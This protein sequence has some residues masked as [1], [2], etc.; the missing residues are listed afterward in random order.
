MQH[1]HIDS[2]FFI[3]TLKTAPKSQCRI[4][5]AVC[6]CAAAVA[7]VTLLCCGAGCGDDDGA[8]P[9]DGG[10]DAAR[11]DGANPDAPATDAQP[12]SDAT[13]EPDSTVDPDAG[14]P[15]PVDLGGAVQK[16]PF[17]LGSSIQVSTMDASGNPTGQ[18]FNTDTENDLGEFSVVVPH[19]GLVEIEGTGFY[20][21]EVTGQLSD[22]SLTLRAW[23]VVGADV[24]QTAYLNLI[25]HL[26]HARIETLMEN[27]AEFAT[28]RDQAEG[29]LRLGLSIGPTNYDPGLV[30]IELNMLAAD[31]DASAYLLAISAVLA[32]AAAI[33]AG[34]SGSVDANLQE[35]LN[36][37][38]LDLSEDGALMSTLQE[39]I[40]TAESCVDSRQVE[41]DL[42]ARL[43]AIGSSAPVPDVDRILDWDG[44]TIAN[45]NDN[46]PRQ[47][48][49][50][51]EPVAG[52][53]DYRRVESEETAFTNKA[54]FVAGTFDAN[55][56]LDL[57]GMSEWFSST[58][59]TGDGSGLYTPTPV[60]IP[61]I[62]SPTVPFGLA[63]D[64]NGDGNGD[65]ITLWD[66]L[67]AHDIPVILG[68]GDGTFAQDS[69]PLVPASN[70]AVEI[71][72]GRGIH[73]LDMDGD[74][75]QDVLLI[76]GFFMSTLHLALGLSDGTRTI[77]EPIGISDV[78]RIAA[79]D[80]NADGYVDIVVSRDDGTWDIYH[81]DFSGSPA[82]TLQSSP[83][84]PITGMTESLVLADIDGD[85]HTDIVGLTFEAATYTRHLTGMHGNGQGGLE[86]TFN[87]PLPD[88]DDIAL[89]PLSAPSSAPAGLDLI[90]AHT[91]YNDNSTDITLWAGNGTTLAPSYSISDIPQDPV[92]LSGDINGDDQADIVLAPNESAIVGR[93]ISFII[94]P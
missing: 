18:T 55:P 40:N 10:T 75:D 90:A 19:D 64:M 33:R 60:T 29:E 22:A 52:F 76:P 54:L 59:A 13:P 16:G 3:R 56:Y 88:V 11:P 4:S 44:D 45:R 65:L 93:V 81:G 86:R 71:A 39:E 66:Q 67:P 70:P 5:S 7:L 53:C 69:T 91:E 31:D 42:A 17:V 82:F 57:I 80:L 79:T 23:T 1:K 89:L 87:I 43:I 35:L 21:N 51:Q 28:A 83:Q 85:G 6:R 78:Y 47:P 63:R 15:T 25:T 38:S 41:T 27:G 12:E 92:L 73:I 94:N 8:D 2:L 49:P 36:T 77:P 24:E 68:N 72:D 58:F 62:M 37:I 46:C 50:N 14:E 34:E 61:D 9:V 32:Q 30:G 20:Y 84:L 26:T 74:G 48:N